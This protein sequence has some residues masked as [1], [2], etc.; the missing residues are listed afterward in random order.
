MIKEL[1][2]LQKQF[3][4]Y[5]EKNKLE[6]IRKNNFDTFDD[7]LISEII[8]RI[9]TTRWIEGKAW[10]FQDTLKIVRDMVY[11]REVSS[12]Y[13]K[14]VKPS[15]SEDLI[16]LLVYRRGDVLY[17]GGTNGIGELISKWLN[18]DKILEHLDA[19]VFCVFANQNN[20]KYDVGLL[21][22]QLESRGLI[23]VKEV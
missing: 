14:L 10:D 7:A 18:G 11:P 23:N 1:N 9:I 19:H 4:D 6:G 16:E 15:S 17:S 22:N 13:I 2:E 8:S 3:I 5:G 12:K 21:L 20:I